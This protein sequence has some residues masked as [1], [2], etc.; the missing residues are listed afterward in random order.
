MT[1]LEPDSRQG[2]ERTMA[3]LDLSLSDALT[4]SVPQSSPGNMVQRDFV[5]ALEAETFDDQVGETVGK[6]DYIPLLDKD[7]KKDG[8]AVTPGGQK[9]AQRPEPQGEV[10]PRLTEQQLCATDFLSGPGK[11]A[12]F[13]DQWSIQPVAPQTQDSGRMGPFQGFSQPGMV[14]VDF[15]VAPFQTERPS[16]IAEPQ[17]PPLSL[18]S[19]PLKQPNKH[20][21]PLHSSVA[22]VLGDPWEVQGGLQTDLPFTPSVSTVISRHASQLAESPLD[23][24]WPHPQSAGAGEERENEGAD[25]K[26]QQQ[27]Q[28]KKKKKRRPRE[29]VYDHM[30]NRSPVDH[31]GLQVENTPPTDGP[32]RRSPWREGGWELSPEPLPA[33]PTPISPSLGTGPSPKQTPPQSPGLENTFSKDNE[34]A[35]P[36]PKADQ[37]EGT[38]SGKVKSAP[39]S[40]FTISVKEDHV[41]ETSV[42]SSPPPSKEAPLLTPTFPQPGK[43]VPSPFSSETPAAPFPAPNSDLNPTALP[44]FP[45]SEFADVPPK[46][47]RPADPSTAEGW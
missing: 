12:G 27:Q 43:M 37:A 28:L 34:A 30:E 7:D 29:E 19:D 38:P 20:T 22:G 6:K 23:P 35:P 10:R 16:S 11:M 46:E 15:G 9:T 31:H 24:Q 2:S 32:Q 41:E 33:S 45:I 21:Q 4:D 14:N 8:S 36:S 26:H 5:A 40:F 13:E 1:W 44:F 47:G 25:R 42:P 18:A 39:E 3:D 17:T